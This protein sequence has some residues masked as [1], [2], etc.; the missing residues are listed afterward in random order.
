MEQDS[1]ALPRDSVDQFSS[2]V[3]PLCPSH[4]QTRPPT[5]ASP[6]IDRTHSPRP[7]FLLLLYRRKDKHEGQ[8]RRQR[9]TKERNGSMLA[10]NEITETL[11][12]G[13]I[14]M[15]HNF[16]ARVRRLVARLLGLE[17]GEARNRGLVSKC[18]QRHAPLCRTTPPDM[19]R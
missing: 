11:N 7:W 16:R 1:I 8:T 17:Q 3:I 15:S 12:R 4:K 18:R 5:S 19:L 2:R 13:S 6:A 14:H 10:C 9:Q